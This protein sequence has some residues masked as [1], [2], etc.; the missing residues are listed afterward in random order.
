MIVAYYITSLLGV[1]EHLW[2]S[3][4]FLPVY[5]FLISK[6]CYEAQEEMST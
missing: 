4:G 5:I 2:Y 6:K 1:S 3:N